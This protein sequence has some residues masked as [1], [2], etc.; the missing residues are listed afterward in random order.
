M[1]DFKLTLYGLSTD[2]QEL[3][4]GIIETYGEDYDAAL[5]DFT[6]ERVG[7]TVEV[8]AKNVAKGDMRVL[9]EDLYRDFGDED[10][11]MM[12]RAASGSGSQWYSTDL[13]EDD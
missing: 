5:G 10:G 4:E 3:A 1:S 13:D 2:P 12:I 9:R 6:A 11:T 7:E 8:V